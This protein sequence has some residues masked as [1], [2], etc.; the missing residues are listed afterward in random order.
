MGSRWYFYKY[1]GFGREF[2]KQNGL[3]E[4]HL[5]PSKNI[6]PNW[7]PKFHSHSHSRHFASAISS[8]AF[9]SWICISL[10]IVC[11]VNLLSFSMKS[12]FKTH[13]HFCRS[14]FGFTLSVV[15]GLCWDF[16]HFFTDIVRLRAKSFD[17][18]VIFQIPFLGFSVFYDGCLVFFGFFWAWFCISFWLSS[19]VIWD[20]DWNMFDWVILQ[21]TVRSH[22]GVFKFQKGC[23]W[24]GKKI[25]WF[26]IF[27]VVKEKILIKQVNGYFE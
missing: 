1:K 5:L 4:I 23:R 12:I 9:L 10:R 27:R 24:S 20:C 21:G 18:W 3:S 6:Y 8:P 13:Y 15:F 25:D 11:S 22:L 2:L 26:L 14:E 16:S 7:I 19:L 17:L